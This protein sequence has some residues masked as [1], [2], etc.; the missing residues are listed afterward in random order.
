[1]IQISKSKPKKISILCTFKV[2]YKRRGT[3]LRGKNLRILCS[4]WSAPCL[5]EMLKITVKRFNL[6]TKN[7]TDLKLF[8]IKG[9]L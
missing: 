6:C 8:L 9:E 7:H 5:M 1:M 4:Q 3:C 2:H